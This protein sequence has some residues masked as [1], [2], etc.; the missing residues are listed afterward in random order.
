MRFDVVIG[1]P[2]YNVGSK[3]PQIIGGT[4]GN[5]VL[6]KKFVDL[7]FNLSTNVVGLVVPLNGIKYAGKFPIT[8]LS[9]DTSSYWGI[10]AGW[11]VSSGGQD[12]RINEDPVLSKTYSVFSSAWKF[13]AALGGSCDKLLEAGIISE[14]PTDSHQ[15]YGI[16][17]TPKRGTG[18]RYGYLK[19][20]NSGPKII[21][22]GLE[23]LSS[24]IVTTLP[25]HVG[26]GCIL[27]FDSE[28]D[29]QRALKFILNNPIVKDLKKR[30]SEKTLGN[31]FRYMRRFDLSQISTGTEIPKEFNLIET[32]A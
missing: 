12:S 17:D 30:L 11:F 5:T 24:Y 28:E 18:I 6:Y 10:S 21:F 16:I 1:N 22:K 13:R 27:E 26:S 3:S 25:S 7:A 19:K 8:Y 2:P 14:T 29:A 23:S 31:V 9:Y 20:D 32:K 15:V 4:S